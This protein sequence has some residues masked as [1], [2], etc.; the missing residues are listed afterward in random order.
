[1]FEIYVLVIEIAELSFESDFFHDFYELRELDG[2][3]PICIEFIEEDLESR[4][5]QTVA[6]RLQQRK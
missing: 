2:S 3:T 5:R 4:V 6:K 1:M